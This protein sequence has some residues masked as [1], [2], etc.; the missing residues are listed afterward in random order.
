MVKIMK[1]KL[2]RDYRFSINGV[3]VHSLEKGDV[4][5]GEIA[6][7]FIKA[8]VAKETKAKDAIPVFNDDG[9]VVI[10][11]E[12]VVYSLDKAMVIIKDQSQRIDS[13]EKQ[14]SELTSTD[15]AEQPAGDDNVETD[16]TTA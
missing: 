7:R 16:E 8:D 4:V 6:K 5:E 1:A 12:N 14:L 3:I 13:L 11:E 2:T 9:P 15:Q 10:E